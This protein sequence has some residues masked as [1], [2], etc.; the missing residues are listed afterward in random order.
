MEELA[1]IRQRLVQAQKKVYDFGTGDPKLPTWEPIREAL[2]DHI[3]SISQYP[4]TRGGPE[5]VQAIWGYCEREFGIK[6]N[7]GFDI[8]ATNGSKEAIFHIA[9]CLVGRAGGRRIIA[10]PDPGYPVYRS[11]ALFAG[12]I[13]YPMKLEAQHHFQQEP[14]KLPPEVQKNLAA[15]WINYPHNPTGAVM[16]RDHLARIVQWCEEKDVVLLA[17]DCYIDIY[18]SSWDAAGQK[19]PT[20]IA[21][22]SKNVFSF[23]S[24]SKRSGVTGYRSGFMIGDARLMPA[25]HTA[26]ANMG[27]GTP[28]MIQRAAAIAWADDS[29]VIERRKIFSRRID[30]AFPFLQKLG[31][32]QE[33]PQ[34]TFY[35]WC[36][37]PKGIDDV[38]FCLKLAE[39]GVISSPSQWLSEGVKGF[40]RF[41]LVPDDPDTIE[42]M[43]I[44]TRFV[45]SL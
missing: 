35:L 7:Q 18:A 3:P 44:V 41:A 32:I 22:T 1:K 28:T 34:A 43:E 4:S 6:A 17:D 11:S 39:Q 13:P 2:K 26:R 25:V 29:H 27:V 42:A 36:S 12:G 20:P 15:L 16:S 33:K 19:P 24:L 37:V 23:M 9:L 30:L 45:R 31:M 38:T 40:A 5:L 21:M 10:Y 8:A 14:W